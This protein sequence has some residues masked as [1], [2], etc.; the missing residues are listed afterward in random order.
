MKQF[1]IAAPEA[2]ELEAMEEAK[3]EG[4]YH[5]QAEF[6][7]MKAEAPSIDYNGRILLKIPK[8]LHKELIEK[9]AQEGVTLHQY[10]LYKLSR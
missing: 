4:I 2:G 8:S 9:S 3:R 5:T 7:S 6:D 10:A 1:P